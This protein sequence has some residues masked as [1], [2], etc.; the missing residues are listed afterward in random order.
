[1]IYTVIVPLSA[2]VV[3]LGAFAV[4]FVWGYSELKTG[5]YVESGKFVAL[6]SNLVSFLGTLLLIALPV[7]N[8]ILS[9]VFVLC[10]AISGSGGGIVLAF[11]VSKEFDFLQMLRWLKGKSGILR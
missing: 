10:A 5:R 8:F 9:F 3:C 1:M 6:G 4:A 11:L 2:L 7:D